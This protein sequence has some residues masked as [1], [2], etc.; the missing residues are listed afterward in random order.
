[1]KR[2]F[3][4][5]FIYLIL[6]L[7]ISVLPVCAEEENIR[8]ATFEYPPMISEILPKDGLLGEIVHEAFRQEGVGVTVEYLPQ[9]RLIGTIIGTDR[10]AACL[11]PVNLIKRREA[12]KNVIC[13]T[14]LTDIIMVFYYHK[15]GW[16]QTPV[17]EKLEDL[18]KRSVGVVYGSN[19]TRF[20][21]AA[22]LQVE[23]S[24]IESQFRKLR[25]GRVDLAGV[26]LLTGKM[27]LEKLFPD[28]TE[29]FDVVTKPFLELPTS[30]FFNRPHPQSHVFSE[31]FVK[32]FEKIRQSGDYIRI[33]EKYYGKGTIPPE[34]EAIFHAQE[35]GLILDLSS[36]P[37]I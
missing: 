20:L 29:K 6:L 33:L 7:F 16:P 23:E 1:M 21:T 11:G 10:F 8:I 36:V 26:G 25:L 9:R 35:R 14:P 15:P 2:S 27:T 30:I 3:L 28:E 34:Y 37:V 22:G 5:I 19:T 31:K 32:G 24:T 4:V 18:G 12:D 17:Y 13:M